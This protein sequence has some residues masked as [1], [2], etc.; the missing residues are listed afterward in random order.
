M[1]LLAAQD[2]HE[3]RQ[4][5]RVPTGALHDLQ[6]D[7]I[8]VALVVAAEL[9]HVAPGEHTRAGLR[10]SRRAGIVAEHRAEQS[11]KA[12]RDQL[13]GDLAGGVALGDVRISC[14]STPAS[15]DSLPAVRWQL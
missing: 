11:E 2:L 14:A 3:L 8:R 6:A 1:P 7:P 9:Q 5:S 10:G 15:C 4:A 13:F 12:V